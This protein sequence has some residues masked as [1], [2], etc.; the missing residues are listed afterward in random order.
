MN[1][2]CIARTMYSYISV[3]IY[4]YIYIYTCMDVYIKY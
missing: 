1:D 4:I 3:Y 2:V